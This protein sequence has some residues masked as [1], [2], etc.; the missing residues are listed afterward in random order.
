MSTKESLALVTLMVLMIFLIPGAYSVTVTT[1]TDTGGYTATYSAPDDGTVKAST[2]ASSEIG[3]EY[4]VAGSGSYTDSH[5]VSNTAKAYAEV[6]VNII[7][8]THYEYSWDLTPAKTAKKSKEVFASEYLDVTY[9]DYI[10]AYANARNGDGHTV[11]VSTEVTSGSL[12]EYSNIAWASANEM[13]A[14]QQFST[15]SGAFIKTESTSSV[16]ITTVSAKGKKKTTSLTQEAG[17]NTTVTSGTLSN[18]LDSVQKSS[19]VTDIAQSG[20]VE[21]TFTSTASAG[22]ESKKRTSNYGTIYDL[23]MKAKIE[24]GSPTVSGRLGYYVD[25]NDS[26]ANK[27]QGAVNAAESNDDINVAAG[28]YYENVV[29]N[30]SVDILGSGSD[31]TIVDGNK[32]GSVFTIDPGVTTTLANM[33]IT[34]GSAY[35]GGGIYN[36]GVLTVENCNIANNSA[37]YGGGIANYYGSTV[38]MIGGSITNNSAEYGGGIDN[39]DGST[40][41]MAGGSITNNSAYE[42]G[43]IF[44]EYGSTVNMAGGSMASNSA[45]EGGGIANYY[46]ST[47]NMAGG[48]I[49]NNSATEYGGGI[50]NYYGSTVNMTGGSITNNSAGVGG[51]IFNLEGTVSM[52]NGSIANNS[53]YVA[54]GILNDNGMV[55]MSGGSI[56]NNSAEYGGGGIA[57]FFGG[58]VNMSGGSIASNSAYEGGGIAN[59]EGSMVN[60]TGGSITNN[61][62]GVGGGIYNDQGTVNLSGDSSIANNSAYAGGGIF[63]EYGSSTVNLSGDSSIANNSA[64]EYG[65]GIANSGTVNMSGGSIA[66]NSADFG[67]G[68]YNTYYGTVNM[69]GGSITNNSAEYYG[70]GIFNAEGTVDISGGSVTGN[71]PD[72]IYPPL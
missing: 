46:G 52:A 16:P 48:S 54:G 7:N 15:A 63:N 25:I 19:G 43:G 53:A 26:S 39:Y 22:T 41:N 56:A 37:E 21:G 58:T 29:V 13:N 38:N 65:G 10:K 64:T 5:S 71:N 72:Q 33:S 24:G 11:G 17:V 30:K 57:N 66:N 28:T 4:Q 70:G 59:Y 60:M 47:V 68:I 3:L 31:K 35:E 27:I 40:V 42:G 49:T 45:Y 67:G 20:H 8:A 55:N 34:N 18:Y 1:N 32:T 2:S 62:A 23:D 69:T 44:N 6:G 61:S 9:A 14:S 50:A 36:V 12:S 51:G